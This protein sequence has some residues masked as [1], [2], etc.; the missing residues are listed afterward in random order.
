MARS[1]I[2]SF[3]LREFT[4]PNFFSGWCC[5]QSTNVVEYATARLNFRSVRSVPGLMFPE[6]I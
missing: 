5:A 4:S 6:S 1:C 2:D 3:L